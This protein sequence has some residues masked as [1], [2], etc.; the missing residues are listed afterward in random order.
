MKKV[1]SIGILSDWIGSPYH[2]GIVSGISEFALLHNIRIYCFITGRINSPYEWEKERNVLFR[3]PS[4]KNV[5]GLIVM[6]SSISNLN[7]KK[8]ILDFLGSYK[9]LPIITIGMNTGKY[10]SV[11]IDNITGFKSLIEHLIKVHSVKRFAFIG[12]PSQNPEAEIREEVFRNTIKENNIDTSSVLY[13]QGDFSILSGREATKYILDEKRFPLEAIVAAN[14]NMALGVIEELEFRNINIPGDLIVTGFDNVDLSLEKKLTTVHQPILELGYKA[15][16]LIYQA[17]KNPEEKNSL[18]LS[19]YPIYRDS[20]GCKTENA[21]NVR[22]SMSIR[23]EL[24]ETFQEKLNDMGEQLVTEFD[25]RKQLDIFTDAMK[26]IGIETF[27]IAMYENSEKPFEKSRLIC[28]VRGNKRLPVENI[29]FNTKELLPEEFK[30]DGTFIVQGIFHGNE[31]MGFLILKFSLKEGMIYDILR[32]KISIA[33]RIS[34][35]INKMKDYSQNLERLVEIK[36]RDLKEANIKLK[37]EISERK[38]IEEKL[39]KSE[40]KFR[41]IATFLPSIIFETDLKFKTEFIN[42]AG[43]ELFGLTQEE[44]KNK[45]NF[46][47]LVV[48]EDRE[49]VRDYCEE[50]ISG[51]FSHYTEFRVQTKN[52]IKVT[53]LAKAVAIVKRDETTGLRWSCMDLQSVTTSLLI[54]EETFFKKYH[55]TQ[56]QRE[57]FL[58]LLEGNRIKDIA[59]K[60][61]ISES[62]V[63]NHIGAIYEEMKV[64]NKTEFFNV[65]K[66]YQI[67]KF[68][69]ESFIFSVLSYLIKSESEY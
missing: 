11:E 4:K 13:V 47:Q 42:Q 57:V 3:F 62:T 52:N 45:F 56:R 58:L 43:I 17:I 18:V 66:D 25:L 2:V 59:R 27:Y 69:Y 64:K 68:G 39:K 40:E 23:Q 29:V 22:S 46:L 51:E 26:F 41:D 19:T 65:L 38:K 49:K 31:Q 9:D 14:D 7:S 30:T 37:K 33:M 16:E 12:G 34:S 63:K 15:C 10:M 35:L 24:H 48:T 44:I 32:Q 50:V 61:F 6:P 21:V 5:D 36:T 20:C 53:L 60:L 67:K 28:A 54:P 55:F 1:V 8:E